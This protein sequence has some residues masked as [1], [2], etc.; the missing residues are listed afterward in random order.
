MKNLLISVFFVLFSG[1]ILFAQEQS[2]QAQTQQSTS[3][4]KATTSH[5]SSGFYIKFGGSFPMGNFTNNQKFIYTDNLGNHTL[6]FN[7]GKF[8]GAFDLGFLIYLGPAFANKHLRAGIDATFITASFN[9][10]DSVPPAG[11]S[12][13]KKLEY[14]Y[15]FGGQKF[16]PL[17]T[18]NPVDHLMIDLSYKINAT[19]A[20]HSSMWGLNLALNEVSLGIRYRF[21]LFAFQYNWGKVEYTYNQSPNPKEKVSV[22][23]FRVL[24]GFK[25]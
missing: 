12:S 25:F 15:Y 13:S 4:P 10:T 20:W 7:N 11:S 8:G 3:A 24:F 6:T 18:I 23:T 1:T 2:T 22:D 21:V 14:W 19:A 9:P 17:L 5:I 16:G